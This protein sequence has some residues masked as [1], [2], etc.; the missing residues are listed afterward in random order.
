VST[1]TANVIDPA[2]PDE[3]EKPPPIVHSAAVTSCLTL[4]RHGSPQNALPEGITHDGFPKQSASITDEEL[5]AEHDGLITGDGQSEVG[6]PYEA[7]IIREMVAPGS[8][9]TSSSDLDSSVWPQKGE[10]A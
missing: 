8:L 9:Q 5:R 10:V 6:V 4:P 1:V 2:V 3:G 7:L